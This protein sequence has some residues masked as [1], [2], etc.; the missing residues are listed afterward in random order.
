MFCYY[1][2]RTT[3][4]LK[5]KNRHVYG[6]YTNATGGGGNADC[7]PA[8]IIAAGSAHGLREYAILLRMYAVSIV[9]MATRNWR[10]SEI[11]GQV[12]IIVSDKGRMDALSLE[13][14]LPEEWMGVQASRWYS[15][16]SEADA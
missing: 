6:R 8:P 2:L 16:I 7:S 13:H 3:F 1:L 9:Q 15:R 4:I 11:I 12:T 10:Y 14:Q 5:C